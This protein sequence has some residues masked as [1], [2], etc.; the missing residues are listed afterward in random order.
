M[1]LQ[2]HWQKL[3][4]TKQ[5]NEVSWYQQK[6]GVSLQ[7]LQELNIP[8]DAS[9]ID[10]GGG[11]SLYVDHLLRLGYYNITV[12]DISAT[13]IE[14][15]KKRLGKTADKVKWI[16]ADAKNFTVDEQ[17]DFWHD[18]AAFHFLLTEEDVKAYL[19][20]A[21][22]HIKPNGKMVIGTF[23]ET[24]PDKCSGLPVHKYKEESLATVLS[25]W[26]QKIKC[27][28]SNHIT[29]FNTLQNFLFCSFQKTNI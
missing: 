12:L 4:Q 11:D 6:P 22:M 3:Y 29:P 26:F 1:D 9:I 15:A 17:Y 13:A 21:N 2:Q 8:K 27:I 23:S 7:F 24:G 28:T 25:K 19:Q 20:M 16:V 14:K 18:R 10:I 5:L